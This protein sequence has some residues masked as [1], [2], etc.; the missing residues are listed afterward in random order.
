MSHSKFRGT[1]VFEIQQPSV[2]YWVRTSNSICHFQS[3]I[4][5]FSIS[6][7]F[8][9]EIYECEKTFERILL[10][11][12][13]GSNAPYFIA[14][15][16]SDFKDQ[17]NGKILVSKGRSDQIVFFLILLN[18]LFIFWLHSIFNFDLTIS[19]HFMFKV[20]NWKF[21]RTRTHALQCFFFTM[22]AGSACSSK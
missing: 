12:I 5:L 4:L 14:G 1:G 9:D 7:A 18:Y 2:H 19:L 11:A 3:V 15:W 21:C 16:R 13:F 10:G 6:T 22:L 17:V 8:A 20:W